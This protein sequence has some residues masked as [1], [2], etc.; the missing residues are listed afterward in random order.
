VRPD[1]SHEPRADRKNDDRSER[2]DAKGQEVRILE[3]PDA[4]GTKVRALVRIMKF[5]ERL[6]GGRRVGAIGS[7]RGTGIRTGAQ[8]QE[9]SDGHDQRHRGANFHSAR[10]R[11]AFGPPRG[12]A[13]TQRPHGGRRKGAIGSKRGTGTRTGAQL[14]EGSDGHDQR[15]RGANFH[16]ARRKG[17]FGPPRG[18]G[19]SRQSARWPGSRMGATTQRPHGGRRAGAT[20][21]KDGTGTRTGAQL[22]EGSNIYIARRKAHLTSPAGALAPEDTGKSHRIKEKENVVV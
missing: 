9:G 7:K 11:G 21:S 4:T 8:L 17:A 3:E 5:A 12:R 10:R 22:Q 6:P 14:H 18:R 1:G 16:S 20:G 2:V 19:G 13:T 15:H